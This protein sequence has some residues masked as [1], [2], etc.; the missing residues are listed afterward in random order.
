M[1]P[2]RMAAFVAGLVL[3]LTGCDPGRT[4][5]PAPAPP[6]PSPTPRP[7]LTS[8]AALPWVGT[9]SAA[10]QSGAGTL[11][12]RTL[13]QIVR[14]SVGGAVARVR[15]SNRYGTSPLTVRA[16]RLARPV[17][18][19]TVAEGSDRAVTFGGAGEVTIPAG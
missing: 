7:R 6:S 19:S 15:L 3:V 18:G 1:S 9:W 2:P 11:R 4:P 17:E 10:V 8:A 5:P 13:R 16:V 12:G 14:T